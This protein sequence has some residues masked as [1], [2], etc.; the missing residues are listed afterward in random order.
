MCSMDH[1]IYKLITHLAKLEARPHIVK[2][3]VEGACFTISNLQSPSILL[4]YAFLVLK[5]T[6][7]PPK[8]SNV[9]QLMFIVSTLNNAFG[10]FA[11]R[12]FTR[13]TEIYVALN[14]LQVSFP[15][16]IK[17]FNF[18]LNIRIMP[19]VNTNSICGLVVDLSPL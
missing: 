6:G 7:H 17:S 11:I 14:R 16:Y 9:Y 15:K 3:I 1:T 18:V 4:L 8:S 19:K 10:G 12:F 2:N 13:S 5:L